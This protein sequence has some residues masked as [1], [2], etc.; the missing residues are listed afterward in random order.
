MFGFSLRSLSLQHP[1]TVICGSNQAGHIF[2]RRPWIRVIHRLTDLEH[3][4]ELFGLCEEQAS[5]LIMR[6]YFPLL[7]PHLCESPMEPEYSLPLYSPSHP[8]P[9]YSQNPAR[10]ETRL[11][12]SPRS[13]TGL[14]PTG[15]FTKAC[16]PATVIL[17]D[18]E[19]TIS[20]P[21]YGRHASV[22]GSLIIEQ[23]ASQISEVVAKLEGRL[24]ITTTESGAITNKV[25]KNTYSLWSSLSSSACPGTI[26][27][28]CEFP[29]TFQ[30][31]GF[32]YPLPPAY[33]ARFPG[34]PS[35][36]VKCTYSLTISIVKDRI[37]GFLPQTKIIYIPIEY[38][39]QTSPARAIPP[40]ASFLSSVKTMPEEW[41]QSSFVMNTRS[42]QSC[43]RFNANRFSSRQ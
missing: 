20:V 26:D 24:E 10:D 31:E 22:R 4:T 13:G 9:C 21:S 33:V 42:F 2:E 38:N 17:F 14:L 6:L 35:L 19:P 25:F 5:P 39:P 37:L 3:V 40:F 41:H 30:H 15:I 27:F 18:Q 29:T 34:F 36:F 43:L 23:D 12:L 16:G 11:D 1:F 8:S 32:N 7:A 28:A